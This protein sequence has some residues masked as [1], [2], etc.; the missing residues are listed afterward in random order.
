MQPL[1]TQ[2]YS[3]GIV[4]LAGVS[5]GALFDLFRAAVYCDWGL[6]APFGSALGCLYA[7]N[8]YH[9][10]LANGGELRGY[11][12]LSV[13]FR[14]ISSL[15]ETFWPFSFGLSGIRGAQSDHF[16]SGF[17]PCPPGGSAGLPSSRAKLVGWRL[18]PC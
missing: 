7:S 1:S 17:G 8:C 15:G 9:L 16:S 4:M 18:K 13:G 6:H 2:L 12:S 14:L 11:V 5:L 10:L 3:F